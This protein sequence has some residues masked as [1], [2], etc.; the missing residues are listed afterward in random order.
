VTPDQGDRPTVP[1]TFDVEKY[2]KDSDQRLATAARARD[3][4]ELPP[5]SGA[6]NTP[7]S[8]VRL[9]TRPTMRAGQTNEAW[10]RAMKGVPVLAMSQTQIKR[11]PL[12][13]RAGFLIA[14]MD[15]AV[16]LEMLLA[17]AGMPTDEALR[18]I[19]DLYESGIITFR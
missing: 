5:D 14:Q 16:D 15:G 12:D 11:L 9:A 2:A 13:H 18:L 17:I 7:T 1:P 4:E 3:V 10:A 6:R 8:E 19:R